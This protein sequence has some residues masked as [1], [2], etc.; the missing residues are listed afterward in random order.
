[1]SDQSAAGADRQP[2]AETTGATRAGAGPPIRQ[3]DVAAD[4]DASPAPDVERMVGEVTEEVERGRREGSYPAPLL[5]A[6][7]VPFHP[8]E[9]LEPPEASAVVQSA[10]PLRSTRPVVG[11]LTVFGKRVVRRLLSWYVAP[12][13]RDQTRFNL[14]ILRELRALEERVTRIEGSSAPSAP[15]QGGPESPRPP[16]P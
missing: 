8:D 12:I 3:L 14:A 5:A 11:E 10:R 15:E 2:P 7:E 9:G 6:L 13:A 4:I 1:M 16:A